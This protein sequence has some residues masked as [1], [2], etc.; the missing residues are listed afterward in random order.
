MGPLDL[1]KQRPRACTDTSAGG[2]AT[3]A[4]TIDKARA[5]LPGGNPGPYFTLK[6]GVRTLS[7][8]LYRRFKADGAE[9]ARVVA[10]SPDEASVVAW[11]LERTTP[12]DI[13]GWN[14]QI[15]SVRI[16]ELDEAAR[17]RLVTVYGAERLPDE[18]TLLG[19]I[20]DDDDRIWAAA[21]AR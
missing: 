7:G 4:R 14:A 10:E 16:G 11:F 9:F 2:I 17:T 20:D 1:T 21:E 19:F 18:M 3:L 5:E 6:E 12:G 13:S 8:G 15:T